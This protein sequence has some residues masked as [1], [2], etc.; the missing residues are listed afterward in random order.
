MGVLDIYGNCFTRAEMEFMRPIA[1][2]RLEE[3]AQIRK[4][5]EENG[6]YLIS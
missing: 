4:K 6:T 3:I 2:Y 5:S 1:S